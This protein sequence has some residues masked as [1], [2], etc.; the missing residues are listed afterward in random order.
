MNMK[1]WIKIAAYNLACILLVGFVACSSGGSDDPIPSGGD[2][3]LVPSKTSFVANGNDVVNFSVKRDGRDISTVA[4]IY[5]VDKNGTKA[6]ELL[7][8]PSYKSLVNGSF[9][10]KAIYG[11]DTSSNVVL[12][13]TGGLEKVEFYRH[14]CVM[15]LTGTWCSFCPDLALLL[16]YYVGS[17]P[18]KIIELSFHGGQTSDPMLVP[19]TAVLSSL[20]GNPGF[21]AAI[22]DLRELLPSQS[23]PIL[24]GMVN[25][26]RNDYPAMG[27]IA[28]SSDYNNSDRKVSVTVKVKSSIDANFRIAVYLLEDGIVEPQFNH[29][30]WVD[31]YAHNHTVR[32]LLSSNIKGDD[33]GTIAKGSEVTKTYELTLNDAWNAEKMSVVAYT[34]VG[35]NINNI[36]K[37]DLGESIDYRLNE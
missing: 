4:K 37:C 31:D 33:L 5:L 26:S 36:A 25:T 18:D 17:R 32:T 21:P 28:L 15:K 23:I 1:N 30:S 12:T 35:D 24:D 22:V 27:G 7:T 34:V 2:L 16:D 29:G 14:V 19:E 20:F 8:Q 6:N 10:F 11:N 13:A 3:K 9:T